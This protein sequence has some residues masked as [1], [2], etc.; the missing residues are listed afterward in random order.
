MPCFLSCLLIFSRAARVLIANN[1]NSMI[2]FLL[3]HCSVECIVTAASCSVRLS[4]HALL[5]LLLDVNLNAG[6]AVSTCVV[7][8]IAAYLT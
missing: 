8:S 6:N 4:A 1:F 3:S 5:S 7:R 2:Y